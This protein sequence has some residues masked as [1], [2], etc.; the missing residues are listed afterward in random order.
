MKKIILVKQTTNTE[1]GLCCI[2]MVGS[3][4]GFYKPLSYYRNKFNVGRD[5]TRLKD[6]YKM[7]NSIGFKSTAYKILDLKQFQFEKK[8]YIL[9]LS[10]HHFVVLKKITDK[11]AILYDPAK[12]KVKITFDELTKVFEGYAVSVET[13]S[14]FVSNKNGLGDFRH[15][16]A[17]MGELKGRLFQALILSALVYI[18]SIY[19][20]LIL[21]NIIDNISSNH[22]Y[23][24]DK[25]VI[26]LLIII[27]IYSLSSHFRN[28]IMVKLQTELFERLTEQTICHLFK[29]PYSFFDN[30][31]QGNILFR[32]GLLS[33][34]QNA[35][36]TSFV[37]ILMAFTCTIV[38][39]VYFGIF[40]LSLMPILLLT[41]ILIG[42]YIML[43]SSYLLKIKNNE[44]D[45]SEDVNNIETEIVTSMFQIKCL[46]LEKYFWNSFTERFV[47]LKS[48]FKY[49]QS[50][51]N[52]VNLIISIFTTFIPIGIL[53]LIL[54]TRISR[55]ISVGQLFLI[56]NLFGMLLTYTTNFFQELISI[57]LLKASLHYLNDMLDEPELLKNGDKE[58]DKFL[59][60]QVNN[61]SFKYNDTSKSVI[62]DINMKI[63]KGEKIAIVGKSGSGK[64]TLVKL[65]ANLYKPV[66]GNITINGVDIDQISQN[67]LGSLISIV[68]QIPIVFNKTIKDNITLDDPSISETE[69]KKALEIANFVEE[70]EQMPM[71]I[72]TLISGQSG[73]LSGGQIQRLAIARA[74]VRKPQ[75]LILD[76]ATSSLDS[77]NEKIIYENLKEQKITS[78]IISH[79]LATIIDSDN[80]YVLDN[81]LI[82]ESGNHNQLLLNKGTYYNLFNSQQIH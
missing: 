31:S 16:V 45:A 76:E 33:Q 71:G 34:I 38:I 82:V 36:S 11:I 9:Y 17:V 1:C 15:V 39:S 50:Q 55:N 32:I 43:V 13:T 37:H 57:K 23:D 68:P 18:V 80:I 25:T 24:L 29:I 51:N 59:S 28:H 75:F 5:G 3:Y 64:T 62:S 48:I 41:I 46:S 30:R 65:L 69:V 20:P 40:Y 60:L 79:R 58:I 42:V 74:L 78:L 56:Y 63:E 66:N 6:L 8:P 44:L 27:M 12:G 61:V 14:E 70:V 49:S 10:N 47:K 73:N 7:L 26:S 54:N 2:A 67:T 77:N 22:N 53:L 81:G 52:L 4:Y 21:R 72:D 35:I 19:V